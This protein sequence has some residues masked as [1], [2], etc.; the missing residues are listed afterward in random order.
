[1]TK[2]QNNNHSF[3]PV[4]K[5]RF[6]REENDTVEINPPFRTSFKANLVSTIEQLYEKTTSAVQINGSTERMVQNNHWSKAR[7]SSVTHPL[8]IF[9]KWIMEEHD[10]NASIGGRNITSLQFADDIDDLAEEKQEPKALLQ[11]LK[12]SAQGTR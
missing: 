1:M 11:S 2:S 7:M 3:H 10:G 12:K 5:M 4:L 9:L 6:S 8:N